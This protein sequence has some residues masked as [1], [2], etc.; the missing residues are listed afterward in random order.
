MGLDSNTYHIF[1]PFSHMKIIYHLFVKRHCIKYD[2]NLT[3]LI[4]I[5][6]E[7]SHHLLHTPCNDSLV[8]QVI[9]VY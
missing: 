3:S 6:M 9:T 8:I 1:P 5:L 4:S 2:L 7:I